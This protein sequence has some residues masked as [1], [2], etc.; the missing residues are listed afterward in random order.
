M[1]RSSCVRNQKFFR[2]LA[3]QA[4][5]SNTVALKRKALRFPFVLIN[6][7]PIGVSTTERVEGL[8]GGFGEWGILGCFAQLRSE[9]WKRKVWTTCDH[10]YHI[11]IEKVKVCRLWISACQESNSNRVDRKIELLYAIFTGILTNAPIKIHHKIRL[12]AFPL[13]SC[14]SCVGTNSRFRNGSGAGF[15]G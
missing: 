14:S 12:F 5:T 1:K 8:L 11:V 9:S 6:F 10:L 4:F 7:L 2:K 3:T 15:G 13:G